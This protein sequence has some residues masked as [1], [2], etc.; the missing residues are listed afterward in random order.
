MLEPRALLGRGGTGED[1]E[2]AVDLKRVRRDRD[3]V[4]PTLAQSL[5]NLDRNGGLADPGGAEDRYQGLRA[6]HDR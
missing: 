6:R 4:L 3:G 5:G 1:L 2:A